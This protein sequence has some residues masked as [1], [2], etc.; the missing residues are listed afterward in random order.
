[1]FSVWLCSLGY[2]ESWQLKLKIYIN[3]FLGYV[4]AQVYFLGSPFRLCKSP[5]CDFVLAN[6]HPPAKLSPIIHY[7]HRMKKAN[8]FV[9]QD[10]LSCSSGVT[11]WRT[12]T[13]RK[14]L[15]CSSGLSAM[16]D[17]I[18]RNSHRTLNL[19]MIRWTLLLHH[20]GAQVA[21]CLLGRNHKW[22]DGKH[23]NATV[24]CK[25]WYACTNPSQPS[26]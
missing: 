6:T 3:I 13:W 23:S 19:Q 18:I 25:L 7:Q 20:S 16:D 9:L 21:R 22:K 15:S 17:W 14:V 24:L 10:E 5:G 4:A 11:G 12:I 1:M 8:M 26:A 2:T